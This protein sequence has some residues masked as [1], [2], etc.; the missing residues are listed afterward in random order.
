MGLKHL[1]NMAFSHIWLNF[2]IFLI[3]DEFI[4]FI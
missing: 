3:N 4:I 1:S 2:F